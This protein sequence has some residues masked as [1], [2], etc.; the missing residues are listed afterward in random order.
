MR[1]LFRIR[2]MLGGRNRHPRG[3]D[4]PLRSRNGISVRIVGETV[5]RIGRRHHRSID[6]VPLLGPRNG[7]LRHGDPLIVGV[8]VAHRFLGF[9]DGDLGRGD[10]RVTPVVLKPVGCVDGLSDFAAGRGGPVELIQIHLDHVARRLRLFERFLR[11][12]LLCVGGVV[13]VGQ[14]VHVGLQ[15]CDQCIM[16]CHTLCGRGGAHGGGDQSLPL[17]CC[18]RCRQFH[19]PLLDGHIQALQLRTGDGS[20]IQVVNDLLSSFRRL[21][22]RDGRLRHVIGVLCGRDA[23]PVGPHIAGSRAPLF[24]RRFRWRFGRSGVAAAA[25]AAGQYQERSGRQCYKQVSECHLVTPFFC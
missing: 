10:G 11:G 13:V 12:I 23:G 14:P 24:R 19:R 20:R 8:V 15:R 1:G 6:R 22:H 25:A 5:G 3:V 18:G 16:R 21:G 17:L 9:L 4:G 2:K 7:G